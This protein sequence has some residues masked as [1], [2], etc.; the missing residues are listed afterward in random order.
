[1]EMQGHG[2]TTDTDRPMT[3]AAMGDDIAGLLDDLKIP[4][5]DPVGHSVGGAS[6]IRA[7]IQHPG[8][9]RR[10]VVI[11]SP[12]AKSAWY[13]KTQYPKCPR[14]STSSSRIRS[15]NPPTGTAQA[16]AVGT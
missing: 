12:H 11:S 9:V 6:A 3:F 15:T 4:Q 16:D 5:A 10:L 2:R 8:H 13:P 7:A 14:L 1:V